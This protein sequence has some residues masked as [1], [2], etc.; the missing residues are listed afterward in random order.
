MYRPHPVVSINRQRTC[1]L[2]SRWSLELAFGIPPES[3]PRLE[4]SR[5]RRRA[6]Q[7]E[8]VY[9][10]MRL[11]LTRR[12][13]QCLIQHYLHGQT[14]AEIGAASGTDRS[15]ACRAVG[16]AIRKLRAAAAEDVSW[17]L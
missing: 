16:R 11:R 3:E 12:E 9:R 17:R 10:Q 14:F 15:S 1:R 7:L 6:H 8:W 2:L 5:A 13:R 4:R